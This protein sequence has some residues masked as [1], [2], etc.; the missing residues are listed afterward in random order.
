[1]SR[2]KKGV[3]L[4]KIFFHLDNQNHSDLGGVGGGSRGGGGKKL[5]GGG[6]KIGVG[7]EEQEGKRS[8][9]ERAVDA[10]NWEEGGGGGRD[11]ESLELS[12]AR[13]FKRSNVYPSIFVSKKN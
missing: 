6:E 11:G 13:N 9:E 12:M 3:N 2:M 7:E 5:K 1:M 8:G 4:R 10:C